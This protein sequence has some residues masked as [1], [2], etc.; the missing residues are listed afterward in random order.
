MLLH[1]AALLGRRHFPT[2]ALEDYCTY[3]GQAL[4]K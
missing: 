2:D 3:L 4:S 1:V